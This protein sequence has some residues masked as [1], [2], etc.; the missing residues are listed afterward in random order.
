[1]N[2]RMRIMLEFKKH[3]PF[4]NQPAHLYPDSHM[5]ITDEA[6]RQLGAIFHPL[7]F[8]IHQLRREVRINLER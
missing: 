3:V 2:I 1:M 8:H 6:Q 5:R 7:E 4:A